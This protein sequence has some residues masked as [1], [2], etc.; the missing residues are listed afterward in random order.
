MW[1][2]CLWTLNKLADLATISICVLWRQIH[3]DCWRVIW[4]YTLCSSVVTSFPTHP[5][6]HFFLSFFPLNLLNLA[7]PFMTKFNINFFFFSCVFLLFRAFSNG[8]YFFFVSCYCCLFFSFS[9]SITIRRHTHF[10][11]VLFKA[12]P[13]QSVSSKLICS[14]SLCFAIW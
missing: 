10:S 14:S 11:C 12:M 9:Q 7:R 8:P 3:S 13:G 6:P 2:R 4:R 5:H 1:S